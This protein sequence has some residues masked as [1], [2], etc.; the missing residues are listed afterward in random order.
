VKE[1]KVPYSCTL[2]NIRFPKSFKLQNGIETRVE[3]NKDEKTKEE[4]LKT[5]KERK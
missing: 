4:T 5:K 1:D 2:N 3:K